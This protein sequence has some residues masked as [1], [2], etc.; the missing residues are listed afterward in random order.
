[1]MNGPYASL[2]P[3]QRIAL[4]YAS[5]GRQA[6]ATLFGLDAQCAAIVRQAREPL[7]AQMRLAWWREAVLKGEGERPRGEPV[8]DGLAEWQGEEEAL[9]QMVAGWEYLVSESGLDRSAI[10]AFAEARGAAFSAFA[11]LTGNEPFM[12][13]AGRAGMR[14]ALA[15]LAAHLS[16]GEERQLVLLE[17]A[18]VPLGRERLPR[19]LR[20]VAVLE[21]L[22]NRSLRTG[23][24]PLMEGRTSALFALRL[25]LFGR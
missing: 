4:A 6:L 17:T 23:A 20:P 12:D 1:M 11:R 19:A 5:A 18:T 15:D 24:G 21:G 22:A 25:G 13:R 3:A 7:L 14:W 10:R 8:L 2:P 16:R 9:A